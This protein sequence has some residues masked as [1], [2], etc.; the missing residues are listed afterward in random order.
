MTL[1]GKINRKSARRGRAAGFKAGGVGSTIKFSLMLKNNNKDKAHRFERAVSV[2]LPD[3]VAYSRANLSPRLKNDTLAALVAPVVDGNVVTW[4]AVP[5]AGGKKLTY[6]V[7]STVLSTAP[8]QL[9]FQGGAVGCAA[10]QAKNETVRAG[11]AACVV[12]VL[13]CLPIAHTHPGW[14]TSKKHIYISMLHQ[15]TVK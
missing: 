8:S 3:G 4:P 15:V 12:Y 14:F 6:T 9:L 7:Y 5:L 2:V 11:R 13:V 1:Y 10:L